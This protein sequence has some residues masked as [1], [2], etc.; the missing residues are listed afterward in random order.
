MSDIEI[1]PNYELI[2]I[3]LY[4]SR[5]LFFMFVVCID[6]LLLYLFEFILLFELL[7]KIVV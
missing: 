5:D 3:C 1:P 6:W 7:Y 2:N 4:I